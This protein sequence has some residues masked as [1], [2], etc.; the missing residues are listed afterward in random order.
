MTALATTLGLLTQALAVALVLAWT[1]APAVVSPLPSPLSYSM[2]M[3][4]GSIGAVMVGV[5]T[6]RTAPRLIGFLV[7]AVAFAW[8]CVGSG[9]GRPLLTTC[10]TSGYVGAHDVMPILL[11]GGAALAVVGAG[12]AWRCNWRRRHLWI[13]IAMTAISLVVAVLPVMIVRMPDHVVG[14]CAINIE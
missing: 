4:C 5:V 6:L 1:S 14:G 2:V 8:L 11:W 13:P 10:T 12:V 7:L 9:I 3:A